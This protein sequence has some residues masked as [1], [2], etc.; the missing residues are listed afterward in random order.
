LTDVVAALAPIRYTRKKA[1]MSAKINADCI[2][3]MFTWNVSKTVDQGGVYGLQTSLWFPAQRSTSM[4]NHE[5]PTIPSKDLKEKALKRHGDIIQQT[6]TKAKNLGER[7]IVHELI[8]RV[9]KHMEAQR[10][11]ARDLL[12]EEEQ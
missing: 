1:R 11:I 10:M 4:L 7:Q 8:R 2:E 5:P 3:A 6:L 9:R 12:D